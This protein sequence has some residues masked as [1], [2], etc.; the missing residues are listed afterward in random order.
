MSISTFFSFFPFIFVKIASDVFPLAAVTIGGGIMGIPGMLIG[1]PLTA[2]IY[3]IIRDDM[4]KEQVK[5]KKKFKISV[6]K[7]W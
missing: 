3:R 4:N 6:N 1:V 7:R 2:T 5:N